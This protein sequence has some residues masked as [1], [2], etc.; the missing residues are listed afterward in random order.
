[1]KTFTHADGYK[2]DPETGI[3]YGLRG[4]PLTDRDWK[5]YVRVNNPRRGYYRFAHRIMW[6]AAVGPIPDGMQINH[7]NGIKDDNRLENLEVVTASENTIH[8]YRTGLA[9]KKGEKSGRPKLTQ[10]NVDFIRSSIASNKILARK[11][12]VGTEAI[13]RARNGTNW[14]PLTHGEVKKP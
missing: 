8:A 9:D 13:R 12:G 5:G 1:M 11:F 7:K 10:A 2:V 6:E 14:G 4:K 3:V